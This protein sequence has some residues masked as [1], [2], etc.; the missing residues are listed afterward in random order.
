MHVAHPADHIADSE[1]I[2]IGVRVQLRFENGSEKVV[3]IASSSHE[4]DP[5]RGI[6]SK[7]SPLGKALL[8]RVAGDVVTY[9]TG[10]KTCAVLVLAVVVESQEKV[11]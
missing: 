7:E 8:G 4:A 2:G 6:I 3:T 5:T 11:A 1:G 10:V 9:S